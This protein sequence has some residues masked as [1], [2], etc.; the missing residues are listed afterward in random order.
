[1]VRVSQRYFDVLAAEDTLAA[2]EATL[3]A[4]SRQLEQAEKRFEVGL[5][6]ITDVQESRAA[7]DSATA[8]VIA[9]KRAL[10]SAQEQLREITGESLRRA[11]QARATTCRS[12][13]RS[14]LDEQ[15]GWTWRWSRT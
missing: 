2:A 12:T 5:I 1:M 11:G 7:H 9:A 6:A 10:A 3:Q 13:S 15:A 8:G 4:F 14:R